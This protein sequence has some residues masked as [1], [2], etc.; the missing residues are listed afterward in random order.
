MNWKKVLK[1]SAAILIILSLVA[2]FGAEHEGKRMYGGLTEQ[3]DHTQFHPKVG[4]FAI[5]NVHVLA[6]DGES[7]ISG[8]TVLLEHGKI[9]AVDSTV[10]LPS[11]IEMIDGSGKYVIPG[12]ID[13]HVHFFQSPNDLLL[14]L[15]NGVT[16]VRELIGDDNHLEWRNEIKNEGRI[17]P[18]MFVASPRLGTFEYWE[19]KFMVWSQGFLNIRTPKQARETVVSLFKG[20]Y[21]GIKIYSYLTKENYLAVTQTADSL[22][23]PTF[24]HIPWDVRFSDIWENGQRGIAHFEELMNALG[25]EF[26]DY[27]SRFAS[28]NGK[29]EAFLSFVEERSEDLAH[30]LKAND[31]S[32]TST[33]WLTQSFARQKINLDEILTEI[34]LAYE[35]PGISEGTPMAPQAIAWLP[36]FNR[37]RLRE[38]LSEEEKA[39]RQYFW[40]T[41]GKACEILA[42][43]LTKYGVKI[44]A[45]TDANLPLAVPGF[46]LHD[47]LISL[48]EAGMTN[49]QVL[50]SATINPAE[51]LKSN[52]GKVLAG[53]DANLLLLDKNPLEDIA[54][55]KA[56]HTVIAQGRVYDRD[57][58]DQI[59][60]AVKA[61]NDASRTVDISKYDN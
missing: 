5:N 24:G 31:I 58:L 13:A 38:G 8:Q 48:N 43:N 44:M 52:D 41:Y 39:G 30:N 32:V 28:F 53:Y 46:S 22:G 7:F 16:Q 20:G 47:E 10:N 35:N 4:A 1:Y 45:G 15:A 36:E 57:L 49:A 37:Y 11:D 21:D 33:L 12:L 50:Q 56:I 55:T 60:L 34:E 29:E 54:H 17:G 51:W 18:K 3:V 42:K 59:L 27:T 25:R 26:N 23:M 9:I 14:Y 40:E 2:F 19:G 6:A 61:A